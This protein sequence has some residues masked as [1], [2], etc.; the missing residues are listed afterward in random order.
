[1][2]GLPD[3]PNMPPDPIGEIMRLTTVS[4]SFLGVL[5]LCVCVCIL[6]AAVAL[7]SKI[8]S[9]E[10][11]LSVLEHSGPSFRAGEYSLLIECTVY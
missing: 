4:L 9:L 5:M 8:L 11:L 2:K 7:Q 1:M 3:D 6:L 10:L